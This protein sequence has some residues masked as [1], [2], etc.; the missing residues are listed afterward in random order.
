MLSKIVNAPL[1]VASAGST[2]GLNV[3]T[4]LLTFGASTVAHV[5]DA[6]AAVLAVFAD[7]DK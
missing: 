7:D 4:D 6:I 1:K 2:L 5:R 3:A